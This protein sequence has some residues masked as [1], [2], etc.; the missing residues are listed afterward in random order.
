M[1]VPRI[2]VAG[3]LAD[4]PSLKFAQ[5]GKAVARLRLVAS[6]RKKNE[7]TGTWED[8]DT[9]W[10]SATCWD[11]LA[12]N[13]AEST[14]KG[15]LVVVTGRLVTEEWTD[16]EG[17]KRSAITLKVETVAADL[18]FRVLPHQGAAHQERAASLPGEQPAADPW[19]T[20]ERALPQVEHAGPVPF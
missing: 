18:Q 11:K 4:D 2:T 14:K 10:I 6:D 8:A 1:S 3:R 19:A 13:V 9:L 7:Q 20:P 17:N 12:E 15:D 5:S 16:R